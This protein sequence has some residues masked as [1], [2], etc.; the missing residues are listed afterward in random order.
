MSSSFLQ[1]DFP[2]LLGRAG[3]S[4]SVFAQPKPLWHGL[5]SLAS[6]CWREAGVHKGEHIPLAAVSPVS[7][8]S[9]CLHEILA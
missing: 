9:F 5:A 6:S 3:T 4:Q 7:P 8:H 2:W 1:N